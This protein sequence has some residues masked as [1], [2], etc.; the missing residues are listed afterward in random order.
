MEDK[1]EG[2]FGTESEITTVP[3][4][5]ARAL[6]EWLIQEFKPPMETV[7]AALS[8]IPLN[9]HNKDKDLIDAMGEISRVLIGLRQ[10]EEVQVVPFGIGWDLRFSEKEEE[11]GLVP[12]RITLMNRQFQS[13]LSHVLGNPMT[14]GYNAESEQISSSF[15]KMA[16]KLRSLT[17]AAEL[18]ISVDQAGRVEVK[19]LGGKLP[20]GN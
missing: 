3:K 17:Q 4:N 11:A 6:G 7:D 1:P 18:E 9:D 16:V 8:I 2:R 10:A 14:I 12:T 20:S 15:R 5:I 19:P 13:A